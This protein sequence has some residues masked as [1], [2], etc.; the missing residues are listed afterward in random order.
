M[1]NVC[2][3]GERGYVRA[4]VGVLGLLGWVG[5]D[6]VAFL[7]SSPACISYVGAKTGRFF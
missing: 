4:F 7:S 6:W 2:L 3:A 5:V 1:L